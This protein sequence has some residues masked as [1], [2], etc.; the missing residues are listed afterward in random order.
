ML[1][2]A[3]GGKEDERVFRDRLKVV[4]PSEAARFNKYDA[5]IFS[6]P[7]PKF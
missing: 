1:Y 3:L 4:E 7:T 2:A 5:I 6:G